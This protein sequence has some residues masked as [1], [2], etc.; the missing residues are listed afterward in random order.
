MSYVK[1]RYACKYTYLLSVTR[2]LNV[3]YKTTYDEDI[4]KIIVSASTVDML[5]N[6]FDL[7]N[8]DTNRRK[9][10]YHKEHDTFQVSKT[11]IL[12]SK[13]INLCINFNPRTTPFFRKGARVPVQKRRIRL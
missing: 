1:Y 3:L 9:S 2:A 10:D 6:I 13:E 8:L 11:R 12:Y 7:L 4:A 5:K